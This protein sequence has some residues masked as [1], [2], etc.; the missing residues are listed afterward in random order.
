MIW[1][2]LSNLLLY[3]GTARVDA[4]QAAGVTHR[5]GQRLVALGQQEPARRAE[6]SVA[7]QPTLLGGVFSARDLVAMATR[8]AAAS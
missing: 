2:P 8:D 6:G 4:A 7:L 1:S 5:A 3:G